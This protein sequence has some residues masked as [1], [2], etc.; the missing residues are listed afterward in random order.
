M[1]TAKNEVFIG[2]VKKSTEGNFFR[3]GGGGG[4]GMSKF[5]TGGGTHPIE[6][7]LIIYTILV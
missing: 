7:T 6:K 2:F 4:E 5:S 3:W 1:I